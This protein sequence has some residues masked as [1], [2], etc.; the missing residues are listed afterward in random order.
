MRRD[1]VPFDRRDFLSRVTLSATAFGAAVPRENSRRSEANDVIG[2]ALR[3]LVEHVQHTRFGPQI[4]GW[5][6]SGLHTEE[7]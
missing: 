6:L 7:F 5:F 4:F 3:Q 2:E 1:S